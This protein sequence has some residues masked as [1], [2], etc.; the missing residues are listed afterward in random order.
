MN[1][2]YLIG[3]LLI[4][5]ML[6]YLIF[7]I[8]NFVNRKPD[9]SRFIKKFVHKIDVIYDAIE[10]SEESSIAITV[11]N[12]IFQVTVKKDNNP[13]S[14]SYSSIPMY[15]SMC[16]YINEEPVC[17]IHKVHAD[18]KDKNYLE[19]SSKRKYIEIIEI[20]E[21]AYVSASA[22]RKEQIKTFVGITDST[23]FY[24]N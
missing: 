18:L 8:K 20:V 3:F 5:G 17:R 6:I 9:G 12:H 11:N 4:S 10:N 14:L 19:F 1:L 2:D 21:E 23:S 24:N 15:K 22:I 13:K 16:V 7:E